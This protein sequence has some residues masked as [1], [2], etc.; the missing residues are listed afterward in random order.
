VQALSLSL[1]SYSKGIPAFIEQCGAQVLCE[2]VSQVLYTGNEGN[3]D[4]ITLDAFAYVMIANVDVFRSSLLD[5][6]RADKDRSLI[7][8]ANRSAR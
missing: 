8:T 1:E 5:R 4:L 3:S 2:Q 6:I 7:I